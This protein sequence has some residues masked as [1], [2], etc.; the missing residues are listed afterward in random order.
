MGECKEGVGRKAGPFFAAIGLRQGKPAI[1]R[2]SV[3]GGRCSG[4]QYKFG[5]A[6]A[7]LRRFLAA[8]RGKPDR[9]T[10]AESARSV[11]MAPRGA[12]DGSSSTADPQPAF[13]A[14]TVR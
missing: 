12:S 11:V 3:D 7:L 9:M 14:M 13:A 6:N 4:F 10:K 2:L 5:L 1:L 8:R